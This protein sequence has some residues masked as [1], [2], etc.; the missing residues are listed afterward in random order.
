MK[1]RLAELNRKLE[2]VKD[3]VP[4]P[5][6]EEIIDEQTKLQSPISLKQTFIQNTWILRKIPAPFQ[7]R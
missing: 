5:D 1:E 7:L 6:D 3:Y 4:P 2:A